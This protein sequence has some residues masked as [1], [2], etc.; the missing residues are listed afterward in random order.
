MTAYLSWGPYETLTETEERLAQWTARYEQAD[1]YRWAIVYER[2]VIGLIHFI[3]L[4]ERS[5]RCEMGYYIGSKW[6]GRGIVT[7]AAETVTA[8]AFERLGMNRLA[9]WHHA[10]NVVSGRVLAKLGMMLE[11]VL[12][13]DTWRNGKFHDV[14]TYGILREEWQSNRDGGKGQ[15]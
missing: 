7:E 2:Q 12:R 6:W 9:A 11:G 10:E 14:C 5:L 13:Q 1:Y 3:D 8:F 15:P 4:S